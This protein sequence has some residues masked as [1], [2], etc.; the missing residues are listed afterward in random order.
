MGKRLEQKLNLDDYSELRQGD[1]FYLVA[2]RQMTKSNEM[3]VL[4]CPKLIN[5][6]FNPV[7]LAPLSVLGPDA[8][9]V[10]ENF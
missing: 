7:V 1:K 5:A 3:M 4:G 9:F 8:E 6:P 10:V 2:D